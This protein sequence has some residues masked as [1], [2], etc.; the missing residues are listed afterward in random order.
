MGILARQSR[1]N[2][3]PPM[4]RAFDG[5][6]RFLADHAL[7]PSR[8]PV[9]KT[10]APFGLPFQSVSFPS[11]DGLLLRGWLIPHPE[12][13]VNFILCHGYPTNRTE[14]LFWVGLLKDSPIN[15]L[16]FDFRATGESEGNLS[17]FG[18]YEVNDVLGAVDFIAA[19]NGISQ[20]P[21]GA[22]G[23]S[24]G[25]AAVLMAAAEDERIGAVVSHGAYATLQSAIEQRF[26]AAFGRFGP[27]FANQ[28][29]KAG[30]PWLNMN[31]SQIGPLFHIG[32]LA[33]RPALLFHGKRDHIVSPQD[34]ALLLRAA[35]GGANLELLPRSGH[36][37][38]HRADLPGYRSRLLG[39]CG[40]FINRT[41]DAGIP[42]TNYK[43]CDDW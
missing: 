8:H 6:Y 5:I 23:L 19:D 2:P 17:S 29:A 27:F 21:V 15:F 43:K 1:G 4:S 11:R 10:P 39:F 13:E 26:R 41:K 28:V 40:C 33:P 42:V 25:G 34:A 7:H 3:I 22:I 12:A 16:I 30:Q 38:V 35:G 14:M 20:L 9:R 32:R 31:F 37:H 36:A 18:I 24:M